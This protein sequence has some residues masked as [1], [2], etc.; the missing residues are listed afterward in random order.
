M[1]SQRGFTL[2]ELLVAIS[3]FSIIGL[4]S[5]QL[6]QTAIEGKNRITRST[7]DTLAIA[8]VV[9]M[10]TSDFSQLV[11]RRIRN[12]YGEW[13]APLIFEEGDYL[14][15]F[16]RTGWI[17][18]SGKKRSTLQRV[19]YSFDYDEGTLTRLFWEV[20]DRAEESAPV[21]EIILSNVEECLV[22][23]VLDD[24]VQ[25]QSESAPYLPIAIEIA[26]F[27][28]SSP[29][30]LRTVRLV[31]NAPSSYVEGPKKGTGQNAET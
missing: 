13:L 4:A 3:I 25:V 27:I 10:M 19:A 20:L 11:P 30:V 18:P 12:N 17:N 29:T 2:I 28:E 5:Y 6:L 16:T 8:R 1:H 26:I 22:A 21:E 9:D 14:V 23:P 31:E 24:S 15:E 7:E